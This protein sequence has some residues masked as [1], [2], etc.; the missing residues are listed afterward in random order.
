MGR[1]LNQRE[2][3]LC[4]QLSA[5]TNPHRIL[6]LVTELNDLLQN[7]PV[8]ELRVQTRSDAISGSRFPEGK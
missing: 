5:E 7:Q 1:E 3:E 8:Q 6:A 2:K 4:E